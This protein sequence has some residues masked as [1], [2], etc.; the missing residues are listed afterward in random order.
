M[1]GLLVVIWALSL[2]VGGLQWMAANHQEHGLRAF[3]GLLPWSRG[4][5]VG[6]LLFGLE[7]GAW[8][9]LAAFI[10][11]AIFPGLGVPDPK[12]NCIGNT[13]PLWLGRACLLTGEGVSILVGALA[14]A[15][16]LAGGP[17][18]GEATEWLFEGGNAGLLSLYFRGVED[19]ARIWQVV[20]A[21]LGIVTVYYSHALVRKM[22][23]GSEESEA[24]TATPAE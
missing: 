5:L 7:D 10:P 9:T 21:A 6:G 22:K 4:V 2:A 15:G 13:I 19:P 11:L 20:A 3:L 8:L 17:I 14:V 12:G 24:P 1:I 16:L 18:G 23:K